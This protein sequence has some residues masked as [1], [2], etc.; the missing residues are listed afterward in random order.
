MSGLAVRRLRLSRLRLAVGLR[1][2]LRLAVGL[3]LLLAIGLRLL[4]PIP[5]LHLPLLI[6]S[7]LGGLLA[8]AT[9]ERTQGG[10]GY[11]KHHR[12]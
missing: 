9:A 12:C 2:R 10:H 5:I 4:L 3:R 7:G 1:L 11:T 8:A 6:P